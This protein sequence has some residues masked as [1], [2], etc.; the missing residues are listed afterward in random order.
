MKPSKS[1]MT[2]P[3]QVDS[4]SHCSLD[5]AC[6]EIRSSRLPSFIVACAKGR[7]G[8]TPCGLLTKFRTKSAANSTL[9]H[10]I[11]KFLFPSYS[12]NFHPTQTI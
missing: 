1:P 5:P 12:E 6:L 10:S 9:L 7:S 4:S 3:F 2:S 8:A 11:V